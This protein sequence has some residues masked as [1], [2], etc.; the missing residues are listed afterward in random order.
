MKFIL[1]TPHRQYPSVECDSVKL[2]VTD[3]INGSFS[4]FYGIRTG[5][6]RAVFSLAE[7]EIIASQ[8]GQ[9][10]FSAWSKGGFAT[11]EKDEVRVT[12]DGIKE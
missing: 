6:A 11:V 12:V 8:K 4:G 5:H 1:F 3:S 2:P 9:I 7:G 10:V